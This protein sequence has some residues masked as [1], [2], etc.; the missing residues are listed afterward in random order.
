MI[1]HGSA[2]ERPRES[3]LGIGYSL[4]VSAEETAGVYELMKFV[5]PA[6]HGPPPHVH[7]REDESFYVVDGEFEVRLG[8][9]VFLAGPGDYVHLPRRVAH[10]F[11]N[12]GSMTG[13]FLCWVMPGNLAGF[14]DAFKRTWPADQDQPDPVTDDDIAKLMSAAAAHGIEIL[15][16]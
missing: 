15:A 7:Q 8:E 13:S 12:T 3:I 4:L 6:G 9:T 2:L 16:P 5:V 11:R 1:S 14:F 10:G